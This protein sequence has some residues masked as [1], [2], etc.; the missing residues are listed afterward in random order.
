MDI[1]QKLKSLPTTL[2]NKGLAYY[3]Q[4]LVSDC[5]Y[6]E[7]HET[8]DAVVIGSFLYQTSITFKGTDVDQIHCNCPVEGL[9]KHG[10]AVMYYIK[11][12][13]DEFPEF[14]KHE[15]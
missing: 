11:N 13:L 15:T 10:V 6:D 9:C 14:E 5:T 12:N 4:G 8:F 7:V 3:Q 2:K 1:Q